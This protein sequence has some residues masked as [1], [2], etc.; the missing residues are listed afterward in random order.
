MPRRQLLTWKA[1]SPSSKKW[2]VHAPGTQV[3]WLL[4]FLM[5]LFQISCEKFDHIDFICKNVIQQV[6]AWTMWTFWFVLC[7]T[8][9]FCWSLWIYQRWATL[10]IRSCHLVA[11]RWKEGNWIEWLVNIVPSSKSTQT[12]SQKKIMQHL[13]TV[14]L[15]GSWCQMSKIFA[16]AFGSASLKCRRC[17]DVQVFTVQLVKQK[18]WNLQNLGT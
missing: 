15:L 18:N 4:C 3:F 17:L 9:A 8:C 11:R 1:S 10:A 5:F 12:H 14:K 13:Q 2:R 7:H 16:I 6:L